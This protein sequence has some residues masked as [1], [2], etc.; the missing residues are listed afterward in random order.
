[1]QVYRRSGNAALTAQPA[2]WLGCRN[3]SIL[4]NMPGGY[5]TTPPGAVMLARYKG[6]SSDLL[7]SDLGETQLDVSSIQGVQELFKPVCPP[8]EKAQ[9]PSFGHALT[10][11]PYVKVHS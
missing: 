1:M 5:N 10:T 7:D 2:G 8:V 9:G 4:P 3:S 6:I 11:E